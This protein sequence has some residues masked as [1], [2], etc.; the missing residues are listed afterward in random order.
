MS[1]TFPT[2]SPGR[3]KRGISF[4]LIPDADTSSLDRV[5][6]QDLYFSSLQ[7]AADSFAGQYRVDGN[8]V[9][10]HMIKRRAWLKLWLFLRIAS[11]GSSFESLTTHWPD[12][13]SYAYRAGHPD[14]HHAGRQVSS[15][16]RHRSGGYFIGFDDGDYSYI[17]AAH[18]DHGS[19]QFV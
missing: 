1:R 4:F 19:V 16:K 8:S 15:I 5:A 14:P 7:A 13:R 3:I 2:R 17:A 11:V 10:Y 9:M 18:I 12:G 6:D